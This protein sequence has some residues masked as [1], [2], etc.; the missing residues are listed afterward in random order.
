MRIGILTFHWATNYG[1]VLQCYALQEALRAL[2]HTV[3]IINYKPSQYDDTLWSFL[4][5]RKF[6]SLA[7]YQ[8]D[9]KK[10]ARISNF[11]DRYLKLS[12]RF[13][14]QNELNTIGNEFD[15]IITGSDQV[16]NKSFLVSGESGGSSAY[17]LG[18]G[19]NDIL[20]YAYAAS[21]GTTEFPAALIEQVRPFV[22]RFVSVSARER[23]GLSIF[24][25][26]GV[27]NPKLV[28]DPT[29][30]HTSSFY[31]KILSA[32][33]NIENMNRAYF[34]R[35]EEHRVSDILAR[36]KAE[37]I[38]DQSIE[39]WIN[40]I[41]CSTH[42]ITNSFH[43]VVFCLLYHIPFTVV[44]KTKE[45]VGMNDRFYTLLEPFSLT[46]RIFSEREYNDGSLDYNFNWIEIDNRVED[47]RKIGIDFLRT[48]K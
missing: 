36:L 48:I 8:R 43:G 44:L 3:T 33:G 7:Q 42:F 40:A 11:R 25:K 38:T 24:N 45:N 12:K 28:P 39:Q 9:K 2:G 37:L 23:T 31:N 6:M 15:A 5:Y 34:L 41:K 27:P 14:S 18:F 19:S 32:E 10:E 29:L 26:M 21:F 35:G 4:R 13:Y 17:Y 1:A 16:L 22:N 47:L 30:L 46:N 20:R